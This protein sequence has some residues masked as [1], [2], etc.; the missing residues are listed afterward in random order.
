MAELKTKQSDAS[1]H[2]FL[3]SITNQQTRNDC[4]TIVQIMEKATNSEPK[5][6]GAG[7]IGFGTYHYQYASGREDDWMRIGFSPRKQ[8]IVLYII[9]GYLEYE[10]LLSKLGKHSIGKSCLYIKKL[11]DINLPTLEKLIQASVQ[12]MSEKYPIT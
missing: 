4:Q 10:E 2:D 12:H 7:I 6:W 5:M 11:S 1:V 9:N 8:N 3:E